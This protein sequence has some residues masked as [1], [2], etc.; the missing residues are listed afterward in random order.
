[1]SRT[2]LA[3][4]TRDKIVKNGFRAHFTV[5]GRFVSVVL[6][7]RTGRLY[8]LDS[9]CH[10]AG[11]PL[12]EG[13]IVDIE[14]IPCIA[15]PWHNWLV[16]LDTGEE[17]TVPLKP[18][19]FGEDNIYKPPTYPMNSSDRFA[20]PPQRGKVMQRMHTIDEDP[21]TGELIVGILLDE[22]IASHPL[23]SDTNAKHEKRG[24]MCIEIFNIKKMEADWEREDAKEEEEVPK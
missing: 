5:E 3:G 1:M 4:W 21:T 7:K 19:N 18:P 16:A 6:H 13:K 12:G 14:D 9:P 23:R 20:G 2:V 22:D 15:C 17:V 11:G 24:A 10:H 8:C